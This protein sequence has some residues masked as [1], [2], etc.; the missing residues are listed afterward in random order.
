MDLD[1]L[2][3]SGIWEITL[4]LSHCLNTKQKQFNWTSGD[5][6]FEEFVFDWELIHLNSYIWEIDSK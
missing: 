5:W 2:Y 6:M 3:F 1:S 4:N